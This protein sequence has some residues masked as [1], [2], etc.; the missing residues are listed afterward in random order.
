[1]LESAW[2]ALCFVTTEKTLKRASWSCAASSVFPLRILELLSNLCIWLLPGSFC[3]GKVT[4]DQ[5]F[6]NFLEFWSWFS[7]LTLRNNSPHRQKENCH[8][9]VDATENTHT[10]INIKI[11]AN[12]YSCFQTIMF[13]LYSRAKQ[14]FVKIIKNQN[15]KCTICCHK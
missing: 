15:V 13:R 9:T 11:K 6:Q 5:S 3:D 2:K 1:M 10:Q 4:P 14:L 8:T 7:L 12:Y